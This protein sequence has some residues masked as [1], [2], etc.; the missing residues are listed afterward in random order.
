MMQVIPAMDLINGKCV[1]LEQGDFSKSTLYSLSPVEMA[2]KI[3]DAGFRRLHLVDLD[4]AKSG[5]PANLHILEAIAKSTTLMVD[6]GGGIKCTEDVDD[7]FKAGAKIINL[8]TIAVKNPSL[9]FAWAQQFGADK[10]WLGADVFNKK[11]MINGWKVHTDIMIEDFINQYA[12]KGFKRFF[13][14]DISKDGMLAGCATDLYRQLIKSF[15][16]IELIAS[17]GV[18]SLADIDELNLAGCAAV[19]IGKAIYEKRIK[20]SDL[21]KYF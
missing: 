1:R 21:K 16:G 11:L 18:S 14:T 17:G 5:R 2:R 9:V 13:C 19:I 10:I 15:P 12:D 20:L 8:G 4:G 7:V 6:Y 3:E